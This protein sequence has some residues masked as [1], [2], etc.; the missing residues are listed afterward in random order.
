VECLC[1]DP[2]PPDP[3]L[4]VGNHDYNSQGLIHSYVCSNDSFQT[5]STVYEKYERASQHHTVSILSC[6]SIANGPLFQ[7]IL[8]N[9][10][11]QTDSRLPLLWRPRRPIANPSDFFYTI[12]YVIHD[13]PIKASEIIFGRF[14]SSSLFSL[15]SSSNTTSY[16][17][18]SELRTPE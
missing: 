15:P 16:Y 4:E 5:T 7:F 10:N 8:L 14:P 1:T 9:C 12:S 17:R 13:R 3:L 2:D 18:K 6:S 11:L